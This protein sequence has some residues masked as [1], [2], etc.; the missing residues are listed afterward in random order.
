MNA[1]AKGVGRY[2]QLTKLNDTDLLEVDVLLFAS[3]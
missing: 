3:S 2:I 1:L